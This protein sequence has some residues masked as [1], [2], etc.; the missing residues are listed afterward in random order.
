MRFKMELKK[1]TDFIYEEEEKF[2]LSL[3]KRAENLDLDGLIK[4]INSGFD[5]R[6]YVDRFDW[7]SYSDNFKWNKPIKMSLHYRINAELNS[8]ILGLYYC[9]GS[10]LKI[11]EFKEDKIAKLYNDFSEKLNKALKKEIDDLPF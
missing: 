9:H 2:I 11:K 3:K 8:D 10:N 5:T 4:E 6:Y 1:L 7:K